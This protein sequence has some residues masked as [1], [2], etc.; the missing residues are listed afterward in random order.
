MTPKNTPQ[1]HWS[2][3]NGYI[4]TSYRMYRRDAE[5]FAKACRRAGVS[6]AGQLTRMIRDFCTQH[7]VKVN[8]NDLKLRYKK[9]RNRR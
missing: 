8:N 4:S 2:N 3:A 7:G 9:V 1:A 6:Q 5:A